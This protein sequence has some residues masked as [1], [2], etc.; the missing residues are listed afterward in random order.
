MNR[1]SAT[2]SQLFAQGRFPDDAF[3]IDKAFYGKNI[4]VYGAGESFHYY[5][6][7]V[8]RGYGYIPSVVL[9]QKF[10]PGDTFEGIPAF[11]PQTYQPSEEE[12]EN[13]IVVVCL[14]KQAYF[15][16]VVKTLRAMGFVHIISL[17]DIYEIHNAFRLPIELEQNAFQYYMEQRA[18]IESCL[19]LLADDESKEVFTRCAET[20]MLRKPVAIPMRPRQEQYVPKD[21]RLS[22]G[23]SR[24]IYCGVSVGEMA[25]VFSQVGK[26]DELV[27]FEPDPD[28][29]KL[30]AEYLSEQHEKLAGKLSA[31]PCAVYSHEAIK[32]FVRSDTSFGSRIVEASLARSDSKREESDLCGASSCSKPLSTFVQC[33]SLDNI[34]PG[35]HPT[36]I[37]MDIEGS[38]LAALKGAENMI[39]KSCPD[40]AICVYHSPAHLWEIPLYIHSLGL[41]YRLFLRNYT[42][43]T[44]ETVLY[45]TV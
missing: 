12:K 33:V 39:R 13:T 44:G 1:H 30:T 29:F 7:I 31:L 9:D 37:N 22:R 19:D 24:F 27:C 16:Q 42:S 14:G 41:G 26:V 32:P 15:D 21:I 18:R 6:E 28:Q 35:F 23:Y 4:I 10:K 8:M 20:H 38:E 34:L 5:K 36:F 45:A 11:S 25:S 17:M 43:F 40:L 3:Y 2:L